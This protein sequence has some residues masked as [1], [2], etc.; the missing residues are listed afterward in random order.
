MTQRTA[1]F[2]DLDWKRIT[3]DVYRA[4]LPA[5]PDYTTGSDDNFAEL[6]RA[7]DIGDNG[8]S[9]MFSI[10]L[11]LVDGS[12]ICLF[13]S[14]FDISYG[15]FDEM[16][17]AVESLSVEDIADALTAKG[18]APDNEEDDATASRHAMRRKA[19]MALDW[20]DM[21]DVY[22]ATLPAVPGYQGSYPDEVRVC[23]RPNDDDVW[24]FEMLIGVGDEQVPLYNYDFGIP[25]G[26]SADEMMDA[27]ENLDP[28]D[29]ASVL[30]DFGFAPEEGTTA[31]RHAMRRKADLGALDWEEYEGTYQAAIPPIYAVEVIYRPDGLYKGWSFEIN[32]GRHIVDSSLEFG[33]HTYAT[34]E[35]AMSAVENLTIEDIE[36]VFEDRW[37]EFN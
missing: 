27:V 31:G 2:L 19:S 21:G 29:V 6:D 26:G 30:G 1:A 15:S 4:I 5:I 9:W 32:D 12:Q 25:Y 23:S 20:V 36:N 16:K 35:E 28:Q 14:D 7:W 17:Q 22:V 3:P 13:N 10:W 24:L 18:Y 37:G 11:D 8:A 34:A 33:F